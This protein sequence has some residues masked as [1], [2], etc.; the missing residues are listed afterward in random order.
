M[1][2]DPI[3]KIVLDS[4]CNPVPENFPCFLLNFLS[5]IP[6]GVRDCGLFPRK[7]PTPMVSQV[8]TPMVSQDGYTHERFWNPRTK[9]LSTASYY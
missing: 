9:V 3:A 8:P 5:H 4:D 6:T 1:E 2:F 7:V